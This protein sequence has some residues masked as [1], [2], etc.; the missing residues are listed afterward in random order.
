ME[1]KKTCIISQGLPASC[2]KSSVSIDFTFVTWE[3]ESKKRTF[4]TYT[5]FYSISL[6]LIQ[7]DEETTDSCITALNIL[8][9]IPSL[10]GSCRSV[11]KSCPTL[12]PHG[13]Q[14]SRL[15]YPSPPPGACSN[16]CPLSWWY[17]PIISFFV[18]PFSFCLQSFPDSGSFPVSLLFASG[19]QSIGTSASA[20]VLPMNI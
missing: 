12:R 16:S 7:Y 11:A 4:K 19:D 6:V 17:H 1:R 10:T 15:P 9:P 3:F 5:I 2:P 13:L 14:H 8:D 20:S 18:V